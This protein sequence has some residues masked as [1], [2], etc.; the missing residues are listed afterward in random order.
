MKSLKFSLLLLISISI[1]PSCDTNE[2]QEPELDGM[3]DVFV[4]C[5]KVGD[6]THYAP[7]FYAYSNKNLSEV[8]VESPVEELP[9]YELSDYTSDKRAFRLLPE[10]SDY[11]TTDIADG[12]YKFEMTSTGQETLRIQD[13]LLD[14]RIEPM[15]ISDFIY[16]EE[17]H[18]FDITWNEL[19][20]ADIYVVK[21]MTEK[22]GQILYVSDRL[23]TT[24]YEF[25]ENSK[26]WP[27]GLELT[28]GTTY[29]VGI[30]AY[31][32]ESATANNG[33][34]INSETVEYREIVW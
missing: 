21:F 30:F 32:F 26:N 20:N 18:E 13:K 24:E 15:V 7:V 5:I 31:E 2:Y 9:N 25:N 1:L 8:L 10:V 29:W 33:N 19:D 4:R 6:E 34:D 22:D 16:T 28:A 3:G 11:T 14:S 23:S 27:I 12:I 17:N